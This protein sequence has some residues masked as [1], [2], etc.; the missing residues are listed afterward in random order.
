[1]K[2]PKKMLFSKVADQ[3]TSPAV[4]MTVRGCLLMPLLGGG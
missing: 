2:S 1:M 4:R 3:G